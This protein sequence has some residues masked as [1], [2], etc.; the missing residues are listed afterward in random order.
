M[1]NK[2]TLNILA[3]TLFGLVA[4]ASVS[5]ASAEIIVMG[6]NPA[7]SLFYTQAQALAATINKHTGTRVDVLP[8][9]GTVFFPMFMTQEADLGIA[10]P[11]EAKLAYDAI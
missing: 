11:V 8:Q 5:V 6:G 10:S 7:G 2:K 9:P 1:K 4:G 3:R